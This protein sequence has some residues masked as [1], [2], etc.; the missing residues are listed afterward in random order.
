M[1]GGGPS[2]SEVGTYISTEYL[3]QTH[4]VSLLLR[5]RKAPLTGP[6]NRASETT[7][8]AIPLDRLTT[9]GGDTGA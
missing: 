6:M 7:D 2:I 4:V 5:S 9:C 3:F 8:W 1:W